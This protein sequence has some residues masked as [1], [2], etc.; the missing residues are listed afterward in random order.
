MMSYRTSLTGA[1]MT[2]PNERYHSLLRVKAFL[3]SLLDPKQTPRVPRQVRRDAR[4]ALKHYPMDYEIDLLAD[5]CPKI[6]EKSA[7][8][9]TIE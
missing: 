6:L 1:K 5:K 8:T 7:R 3:R 9:K 4:S 2:L